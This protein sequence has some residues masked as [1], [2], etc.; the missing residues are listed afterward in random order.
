MT[1]EEAIQHLENIIIFSYQDGLTDEAR[2]A[3]DV[4]IKSSEVI[5]KIADII[6]GKHPLIAYIQEDVMRYK[7]I[8]EIIKE[9][10]GT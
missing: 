4:A 9:W 6:D 8:E 7:M 3:L 2:E 5:Q 1:R 10:K